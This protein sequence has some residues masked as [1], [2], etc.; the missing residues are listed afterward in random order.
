MKNEKKK[1][2]GD[3]KEKKPINDK[4]KEMD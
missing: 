1:K 4:C 3:R 2:K